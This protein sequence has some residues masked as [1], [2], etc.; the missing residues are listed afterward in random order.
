MAG[1]KVN[2]NTR[3][4]MSAYFPK[5][6]IHC[7][8]VM[9]L[10]I[11]RAQSPTVP[12]QMREISQGLDR[13]ADLADVIFLHRKNVVDKRARQI[14]ERDTFLR[15]PLSYF[16]LAIAPQHSMDYSSNER[17]IQVALQAIRADQRLSI[18]K[19]A[20]IFNIPV[21]TL[22]H[23]VHGRIARADTTPNS[24]NLTPLEEDMIVEE[25][26]DLD[27]RGSPPRYSDVEN[28]ANRL[29]AARD[30]SRV[31]QRWASN[32]VKRQ[33]RLRTRFTRPYDYQR[34]LG[35]NPGAIH[36][37][38]ELF[39]NMVAKYGILDS[40]IWNFDETGFLMGQI[41]STLIVTSSDRR[42]KA[43]CLQPGNREWATVIQGINSSGGTIPPFIIVAGQNH[44]EDWYRNNPFPSDWVIAV[45]DNGWITWS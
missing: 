8:K 20:T 16:K 29:R 28:M 7:T 6:E 17:Q 22:H 25:I 33:P 37:S 26:L 27:S 34:A 1:G 44:L 43:K 9:K 18:R 11:S 42:G 24:R 39:R 35:E 10:Q 14:S 30:A 15:G 2:L 3:E 38:F 5:W 41:T 23:R 13:S 4:G 19:A 12:S 21:P 32:F 36:A 45:S 40:D 31:G